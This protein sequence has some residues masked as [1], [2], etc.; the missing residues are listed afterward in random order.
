[1]NYILQRLQA[2][3]DPVYRQREDY[4]QFQARVLVVD[5]ESIIGVRTPALRRL[6]K[7][8][9]G[10]PEASEFLLHL[11]HRY[12]EEKMLHAYLIG[13]CRDYHAVIDRLQRFLPYVD[14]WAT[15][16]S[17]N[18]PVF[19]RHTAELLP[20]VKEWLRSDHPFT[21]RYAM[22]LLMA[23]YL[24]PDTFRLEYLEWVA[25]VR[26]EEYYVNMMVAW[27]FAT[28]L[29][30]QWHAA[31]PYIEQHRLSPW[32]HNKAIQKSV[33]SYRITPEQK[34][35]LRGFREGSRRSGGNIS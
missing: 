26:S 25:A 5:A 32:C 34:Q 1:M 16:D 11:P 23:F 21:K 33:E 24:A 8:L 19:R 7:E 15:C 13:Q 35:Y 9:E 6:A 20:H 31:V 22:G 27:Y 29:A 2:L 28:A 17:M 30:K 10:T 4:R 18:A 14:N 3:Q 12:H